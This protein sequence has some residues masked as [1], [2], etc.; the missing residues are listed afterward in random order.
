MPNPIIKEKIVIGEKGCVRMLGA[1]DAMSQQAR[2]EMLAYLDQAVF[3]L[4][5]EAEATYEQEVVNV[6][7]PDGVFNKDYIVRLSTHE[8]FFY[9]QEPLTLTEF[10]RLCRKIAWYA[11]TSHAGI[12]L[13]L[14]SF[15]V[16]TAE[17][18]VM[19]VTPY[20][21]L[22]EHCSFHL[23]V[24]NFTS[25]VDMRYQMPTGQDQTI[26]LKPLDTRTV[27]GQ[28][29]SIRVKKVNYAFT[30]NNIISCKTELGTPFLTAVDICIDHLM[31]V[32]RENM[33]ALAR[34][35][36]SQVELPLSHLVISNS[37][38]LE[39]DECLVPKVIHVD[40][41]ETPQLYPSCLSEKKLAI[42]SEPFFGSA[43]Y[44]LYDLDAYPILSRQEGVR[45][46]L[47]QREEKQ[48][49]GAALLQN[50]IPDIQ[51]L[52]L[53]NKAQVNLFDPQMGVQLFF[54]SVRE[55]TAF[56]KTLEYFHLTY[57]KNETMY[58][59]DCSG[60]FLQQGDTYLSALAAHYHIEQLGTAASA[61]TTEAE[62]S[63][64][65]PRSCP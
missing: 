6:V 49:V 32:A 37:T 2:G 55:F 56:I 10:E 61:Q 52:K 57:K 22:G 27:Q 19:N 8:F 3:K 59:V 14:G 45:A 48:R 50:Y 23:L 36:D 39:E 16:V 26:L 24:K 35:G 11:E 12:H 60:S 63:T 33:K 5:T 58:A 62:L 15:A 64:T 40:P 44:Q 41:M 13:V 31:G 21:M 46:C 54:T 28:L 18:R 4:I 17:N 7:G 43:I 51:C 34:S 1:T 65:P 30:F 42:Q 25:K 29:P 53:Y 20:I 47:A 9:T 38:Q